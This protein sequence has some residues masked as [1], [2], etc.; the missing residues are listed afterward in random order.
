[1]CGII[2]YSGA[3]DAV[4][5]VLEG[6]RLLEYRG[7]DSWGVAARTADGSLKTKKAVGKISSVASLP[8][9]SNLAIGHTRW[10]TH[11]SVSGKNAHP[12]I[13]N[14]GE[15]AVVHNGIVENHLT[16]RSRLE[17]EGFRFRSETD[18]EVIPNLIQH[19]MESG[20]MDFE[21]A[22]MKT[23]RELKG[24]YAFLAISKNFDGLV[25]ARN[26]S[27]LVFGAG[28]KGSFVASDIPA[29]LRQTRNVIFLEDGEMAVV[30]AGKNQKAEFEFLS[31]AENKKI[32]KK[33]R[34]VDWDAEQAE[35]GP[36]AHFMLKE[37]M[38]QQETILRAV[39][40]DERI[41]R[42]ASELIKTS[43]GTFMVG[44]GTAGRVA[45]CGTYLFSK[46]AGRHVN[47][48]VG[49]EFPN[50]EHFLT[51][52]TL[53]VP[54]S[55]SGE[56]ADTLEAIEKA[57]MKGVKVLSIVNS[58]GSSIERKSDF[59]IPVNCG[60]EKAVASTKATTAQLAIL[61]LL[62]YGCVG[63]FG[64]GKKLLSEAQNKINKTIFGASYPK[65]IRVLAE[66]LREKE[67]IYI[68]G[69]GLNYPMA[70]EAAIKLQEVS[71]IHAEGFAGGELKHGPIALI[72]KGT[73]CIALV[74]NDE[75]KDDILGNAAEVK[76][77]GGFIIGISPQNE[78]V[79]DFW[80]EVPDAGNASPIANII[81]VQLLS[82]YLAVMRG[83]DVDQPRNLA[84]SVT[85]K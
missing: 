81:P 79:F 20:G 22:A 16:L 48:S 47:F 28:E 57:K 40:Q 7:Y 34:V 58:P 44:C 15:I 46:I 63:K 32:S 72:E 4:A 33:A 54:I 64:E 85:V 9:S 50:Y 76:S 55:Q 43:F 83:N 27:P 66:R 51:K 62:A 75:T 73:P 17:K 65:K 25:A 45:L 6:L 59:T 3:G 29:F 24:R 38:E 49:S 74:A 67:N 5:L 61:T 53:M 52:K 71:Y 31:I 35:K 80:L 1:M 14:S 84:K 36:Y 19:F 12:Q 77:R 11:G 82:Y 10:A 18:T 2:G 78:Q 68:I 42:K 39:S 23:A 60:P 41:F 56:T 8:F 26:G 30:R 21:D 69:R 37:I 13:S 70:L